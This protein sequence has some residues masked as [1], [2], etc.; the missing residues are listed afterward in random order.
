[1][2][3]LT[4]VLRIETSSKDIATFAERGVTPK[5][6]VD[7][8]SD[9][10]RRAEQF[11]KEVQESPLDASKTLDGKFKV[12]LPYEKI[13]GS[14]SCVF[15]EH[16]TQAPGWFTIKNTTTKEKIIFDGHTLHQLQKHQYFGRGEHWL[17]PEKICEVL[18]VG[19]KS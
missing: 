13:R 6:V 11:C 18:E 9:L 17:N 5:E 1:M 8:I 7:K 15:C 10:I 2:T 16:T 3:A 14:I 12:T 4:S 19:L